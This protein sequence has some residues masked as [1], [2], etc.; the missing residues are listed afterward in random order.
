MS[1]AGRDI[2]SDSGS[3]SHSQFLGE[4]L[5]RGATRSPEMEDEDGGIIL[6]VEVSADIN[7]HFSISRRA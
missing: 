2:V 6:P 3:K 1:D 4:R 5:P 7:T